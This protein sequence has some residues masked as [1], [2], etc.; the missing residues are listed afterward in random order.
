MMHKERAYLLIKVGN[1]TEAIKVL[2]EEC[3][4]VSDIIEL[5]VLFNINDDLLWEEILLKSLGKTDKIN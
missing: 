3:E 4:C 5:A 2:I 1:K